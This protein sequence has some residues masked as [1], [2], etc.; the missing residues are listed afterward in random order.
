MMEDDDADLI[1]NLVFVECKKEIEKAERSMSEIESLEAS[2]VL[3]IYDYFDEIINKIDIRRESVIAKIHNC[4]EAVMEEIKK[5]KSNCERKLAHDI[6][7]M[8]AS[9][10]ESKKNLDEYKAQ[11]EKFTSSNG[12]LI[13]MKSRVVSLN[14]SLNK[15]REEHPKDSFIDMNYDFKASEIFGE[16]IHFGKVNVSPDYFGLIKT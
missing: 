7:R 9:I 3:H 10:Q 5:I 1:S 12:D 14:D 13:C 15:M 16:L 11:L 4:S 8:N 6:N 2:S